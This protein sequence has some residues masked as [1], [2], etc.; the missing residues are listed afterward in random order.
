MNQY[1]AAVTAVVL[2]AGLAHA[3][4]IA[5]GNAANGGNTIRALTA[6]DTFTNAYGHGSMTMFQTFTNATFAAAQTAPIAT[7]L[8][9]A[10]PAWNNSANTAGNFTQ[11]GLS[12]G[13]GAA[14]LNGA[15]ARWVHD[16]ADYNVAHS[17]LYAIP[18]MVGNTNFVSLTVTW[19][20][21]NGLG[22]A[23]GANGFG[24]PAG[25][26]NH[27][28]YLNGN[29]LGYVS[30]GGPGSPAQ[31]YDISSYSFGQVVTPN[32]KNWL[33]L[34]QFNWGGPGGSAFTLDGFGIE[35]VTIP[36]PIAALSGSLGLM[37][38]GARRRRA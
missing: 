23:G 6:T 19:L 36:N 7:T 25:Y 10:H 9:P 35:A 2:S 28:I 24:N 33:Y 14:A 1:L 5:S 11:T 18:F 16:A 8:T 31:F 3:G 30:P 34:Y 15:G 26:S 20:T 27:G 12:V 38:V 21:D 22:N 4:T 17:V 32:S 37:I 13:G 29:N